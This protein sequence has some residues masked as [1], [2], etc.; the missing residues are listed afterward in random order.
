MPDHPTDALEEHV[1]V[2]QAVRDLLPVVDEVAAAMIRAY[3][4][5]GQV[6]AFGNGG[7]AAD[8]QHL[9]AELVGRYRAERR[10]LPACSLSTDPSVVTCIAN[11]YSFDDVFARQVEALARPGDL[12]VGVTTSGR[13]ENVVRGL[14]AA[15]ARGATTVLL[16]GG[17]GRPASE[18]ADHA[19]VVPS[20]TTARIQEM[21][22][23]L[24]HLIVDQVDEWASA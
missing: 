18:H 17:D 2:A 22:V 16:T 23:L 20:E 10:P 12:A 1:A 21:H 4:S 6:I 15:R 13:S 14:A 7:S 11:D 24:L 8:A 9:A 5:G 19:L 3:E